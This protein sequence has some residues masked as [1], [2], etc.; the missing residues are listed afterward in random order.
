VYNLGASGTG[1]TT[2]VNTLCGSKVLTSKTCDNP[3]EAHVEDD[4][5]IRPISVGKDA[6]FE[7]VLKL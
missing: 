4:I 1:R 6:T 3:E 2:F 5:R 7:E